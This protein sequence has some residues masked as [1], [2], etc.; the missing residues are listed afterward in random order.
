MSS[1][2]SFYRR[3]TGSDSFTTMMWSVSP[4]HE[5]GLREYYSENHIV[6]DLCTFEDGI[7]GVDFSQR[8]Y[9]IDV[10]D[11]ENPLLETE[12]SEAEGIRQALGG[13]SRNQKGAA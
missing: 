2:G 1:G 3:S 7:R 6:P 9:L 13:T 10:T 12:T 8:G 11:S 5:S 4:G